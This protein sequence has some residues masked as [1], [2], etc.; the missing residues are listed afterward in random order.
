MINTREKAR[1]TQRKLSS[2][3]GFYFVSAYQDIRT[4]NVEYSVFEVE[5]VEE[6]TPENG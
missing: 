6:P 3:K 4:L 2:T 1:L 5:T